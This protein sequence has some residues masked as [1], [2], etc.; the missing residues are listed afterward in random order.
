[1]KGKVLFTEMAIEF[2]L[3]LIMNCVQTCVTIFCEIVAYP[4]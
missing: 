2:F 1:M 3:S 4:L